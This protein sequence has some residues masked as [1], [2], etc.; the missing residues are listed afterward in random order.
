M[1]AVEIY[2]YGVAEPIV[3]PTDGA[4]RADAMAYFDDLKRTVIEAQRH[5]ERSLSLAPF[6]RGQAGHTVEPLEIQR[7]DLAERPGPAN[8]QNQAPA[9]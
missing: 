7:L 9:A 6:Q 3:I 1:L 5:S 8:D 2:Y 4:D